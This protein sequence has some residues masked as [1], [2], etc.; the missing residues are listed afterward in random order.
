MALQQL[1]LLPVARSSDVLLASRGRCWKVEA[2]IG[3]QPSQPR[4]ARGARQ[5]VGPSC[6]SCCGSAVVDYGALGNNSFL[7]FLVAH[8]CFRV[9]YCS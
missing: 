4:G 8:F 5:Q 9:H 1:L 2:G 7:L 3:L 6:M